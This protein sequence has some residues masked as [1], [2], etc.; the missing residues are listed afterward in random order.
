MDWNFW[1]CAAL[2]VLIA[3]FLSSIELLT[4][5]QTRNVWEIFYSWYYLG[6]ALLNAVFCFLVYLALPF[7]KIEINSNVVS[8][9]E[10]PL[11]RAIVAG[12]GYLVIAR[13]SILDIKTPSGEPVGVGFDAVYNGL[14]EYLLSFHAKWVKKKIRDDF[15]Q[16]FQGDQIDEPLVF[17]SAIKFIIAQASTAD[18]QRSLSDKLTLGEELPATE[19]CFYL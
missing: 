8:L 14:A 19:Y 16:V 11:L 13:T 5:Y 15:F 12:L 17:L 7:L 9:G 6:F 4:K 10:Q 18:E 1:G 3:V 2:A